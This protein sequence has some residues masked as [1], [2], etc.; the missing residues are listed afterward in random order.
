[1][2]DTKTFQ[3]N[4]LLTP[5]DAANYLGVSRRTLYRL[6]IPSVRL[7]ERTVRYLFKQL[8]TWVEQKAA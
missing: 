3:P 2:S 7:S 5:Q 8:V 4:D 1:M 6:P